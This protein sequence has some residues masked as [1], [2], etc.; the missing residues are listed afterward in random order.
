[1]DRRTFLKSLAIGTGSL[2]LNPLSVVNGFDS[3]IYNYEENY[4]A[5]GKTLQAAYNNP[6]K[7]YTLPNRSLYNIKNHINNKTYIRLKHDKLIMSM[8]STE[9]LNADAV[10][11]GQIAESGIVSELKFK[12]NGSNSVLGVRRRDDITIKVAYNNNNECVYRFV[13]RRR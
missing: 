10:V 7:E 8:V 6:F 11:L 2:L 9:E 12:D 13:V 5:L 3:S 1:M 4:I